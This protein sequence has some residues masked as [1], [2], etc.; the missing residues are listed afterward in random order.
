MLMAFELVQE[1]GGRLKGSY[2][3]SRPLRKI[4]QKII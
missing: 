2:S 4:L 3:S 1:A